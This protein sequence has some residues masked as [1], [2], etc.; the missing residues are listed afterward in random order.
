[1]SALKGL[2]VIDLSRLL[3]GPFCS[4]LLGDH[5]ADVTVVE[6]PRFKDSDVLGVVPM[7]RRNK[8]HIAL[9][10]SGQSG[11][12]IF[13][14][15]V[16]KSDV[17]VEG[18]RPGVV[19]KLGVDY[20][21]VRKVNDRIIYCS[22]TGYG[23]D[24]PFRDKAGHDLNYMALAGM[25]DLMRDRNGDLTEPNFQMADLA[26]SLYAALGVLL[27]LQSRN[28]NG[29]GQY[30]DVSMTDGLVSLLAV[31]LT[32]TFTGSQFPG[33]PDKNESQPYPCYRL[34]KTKD[35]GHL[36]IGPLEGHLWKKLCDK[37]GKPEYFDRQYDKSSISEITLGL[38]EIFSSRNLDEWL[39]FLDGPDY[40]VSRVNR[41]EDLPYEPQ[42]AHRQMILK[43]SQGL[44]MPG[45]TPRLSETPPSIR[46]ESYTFGGD[47]RNIL[48]ELGYSKELI[49][50]LEQQGVTWSPSGSLFEN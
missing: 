8:R 3:P 43:N 14:K 37:L 49:I 10:L 42:L 15:L 17:L 16:Q 36:S 25:L 4:A 47:T 48:M 34:Y 13:F 45:L 5:G 50:G 32:F 27:A 26:G 40:C 6:A 46:K 12:E 38:E 39:D 31:P 21:S 24:G 28:S 35:G 22:L 19:A 33:R 7:L 2:K 11:R 30:I 18:F 9:D 23:Q 41:I 29:K 20:E 1:M 44:L